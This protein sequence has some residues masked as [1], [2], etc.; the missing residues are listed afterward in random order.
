[1]ANLKVLAICGSLREKSTNYLALKIAEKIVAETGAEVTEIKPKDL[2]LP[3]FDED[4]EAVGVP[5]AVQKIYDQIVASDLVLIASPEYNHSLPGGLK[6]LIDWTSRQTNAWNNK[7]VAFFGASAGSFGTVRM[8]PHL[9]QILACLN[10]KFVSQPQVHLAF[11]QKAFNSDGS[12]V[13]A[14]NLES[15]KTLIFATVE[16]ANKYQ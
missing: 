3:I 15:L 2:Q 9:R 1:M 4:I 10:A 16:L 14:K 8:Q 11:G 12:F 6:N 5:E 7:V 13:E